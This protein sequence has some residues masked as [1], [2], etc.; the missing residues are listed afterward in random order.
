[1][2]ESMHRIEKA[3]IA[4]G[5]VMIIPD[6]RSVVQNSNGIPVCWFPTGGNGGL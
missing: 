4:G 5:C 3:A 2:M 1:M 6:G